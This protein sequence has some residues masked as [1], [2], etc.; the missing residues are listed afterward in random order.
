MGLLFNTPADDE[1]EA[2]LLA[3][4][5]R[6][7]R[8]QGLL[9]S[10]V[11]TT[12]SST[13]SGFDEAGNP[14][15]VQSSVQQPRIEQT[16]FLGSDRGP[17]AQSQLAAGLAGTG[18]DAGQIGKIVD[19]FKAQTPTTLTRN[20]TTAGVD[21][22][23]PAGQATMLEIIKRPETQI[24]FNDKVEPAAP[25]TPAMKQEAGF[26][27]E[28]VVVTN[29]KS[30]VPVVVSKGKFSGEQQL[31]GGFALR[32]D[33]ATETIDKL[34]LENPD[35]D[36]ANAR[37]AITSAG[38]SIGGGEGLLSDTVS[39][40]GNAARS[41]AGQQYQQATANWLSANLRKE[42][43]AALGKKEIADERKKW[44][45]T[46]GEG[47]ASK[48]QKRE[49]RKKQELAMQGSS[50]GVYGELKLKIAD[51]NK[52]AADIARNDEIKRRAA[53]G[54]VAAQNFLNNTPPLR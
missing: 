7:A 39:A 50:A 29:P 54:D 37:F 52:I 35:F 41:D 46:F 5:N 8:I 13:S 27:P 17:A 53:N 47:E 6:R 15:N 38:E 3:D 30:G 20:L 48:L 45:P 1:R 11:T 19:P 40:I 26:A 33:D 2:K 44:F 22:N 43:G 32:M 18:L 21:L 23:T 12:G 14:I 4:E 28:S 36:P 42:S 9:G 49:A 51:Q 25:W 24:N 34:L 31:S 10:T 16:G